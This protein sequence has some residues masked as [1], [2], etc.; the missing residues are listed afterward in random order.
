MNVTRYTAA[1]KYI[2][3]KYGNAPKAELIAFQKSVAA[4]IREIKQEKQAVYANGPAVHGR[5]QQSQLD[6]L[7]IHENK[8]CAIFDNTYDLIAAAKH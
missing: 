6:V 7:D 4:V 1:E 8:L 3:Y 2:E 5:F